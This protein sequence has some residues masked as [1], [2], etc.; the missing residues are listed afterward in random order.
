MPTPN[1]DDSINL[2]MNHV[3]ASCVPQPVGNGGDVLWRGNSCLT[4]LQRTCSRASDAPASQKLQ[5]ICKDCGGGQSKVNLAFGEIFTLILT[6]P[7]M[8]RVPRRP[9][10]HSCSRGDRSPYPLRSCRCSKRY[11]CATGLPARRGSCSRCV[12]IA[13]VPYLDFPSVTPFLVTLTH[14]C[15]RGPAWYDRRVTSAVFALLQCPHTRTALHS[16]CPAGTGV[17]VPDRH[18]TA[19]KLAMALTQ[20]LRGGIGR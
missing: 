16:P 6:V 19:R 3:G 17:L 10:F 15:R 11:Y 4:A 20:G 18:W 14:G 9:R 7:P 12:H 5:L 2:F 1:N 8:R 13:S